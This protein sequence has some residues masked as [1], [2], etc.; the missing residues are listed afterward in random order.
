MWRLGE[1][2]KH[3][4][5]ENLPLVYFTLSVVLVMRWL[6][7]YGETVCKTNSI[8]GYPN[9]VNIFN[10]AICGLQATQIWIRDL[11]FIVYALH[12]LKKNARKMDGIMIL[13]AWQTY[14][15]GSFLS[16]L[17][18][19][20]TVHRWINVL[21]CSL[22]HRSGDLSHLPLKTNVLSALHG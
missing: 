18:L 22:P 6:N 14:R 7:K 1:V 8:K 16:V 4:H 2:Q 5:L 10:T 11:F 17:T 20:F 15:L 9:N 12:E 3:L 19:S 13:V 21:T